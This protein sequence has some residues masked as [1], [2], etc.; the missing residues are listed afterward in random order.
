MIDAAMADAV[1]DADV[2]APAVTSSTPATGATDVAR[3]TTITLVFSEGVTNVSTTTVVVDD[4]NAVTGTL[5]MQSA[6][7]YVFTPTMMLAPNATVTVTLTTGITD[8]AGNA[9]AQTVIS[10]ATGT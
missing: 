2:T 6:T 3:T 7:T 9:L 10:F 4:G 8:L 5:A 1:P